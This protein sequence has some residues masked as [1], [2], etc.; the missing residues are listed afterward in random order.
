MP[1]W[2]LEL[3]AAAQAE[4]SDLADH[5]QARFLYVA[6]LLEEFGPQ[7]IGMPH[8]R[9]IANKLWEMRLAGRSGIARAFYFAAPGRRLIVVRMFVKKTER[10][11]RQ[12]IVL[13]ERRMKEWKDAEQNS[14]GSSC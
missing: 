12:E 3:T 13:A 1:R 6:E 7:H 10:T 8:V 9:P 14:E 2:T 5:Y 11:P 4:L